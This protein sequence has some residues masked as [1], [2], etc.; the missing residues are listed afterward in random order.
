MRNWKNWL[1]PI[2][3]G[4]MVVALAL[5]PWRLSILRDESLT[6]TV[7]AEELAEDSNFPARPPELLGR[8]W[9]LVQRET[10]YADRMTIIGQALADSALEE[11]AVQ[12][13]AELAA[14]MEAGALPEET[15]GAASE[16]FAEKLC[17]RDQADLSSASFI[18]LGGYGKGREYHSLVLDGETGQLLSLEMESYSVMKSD[19]DLVKLGGA[20]LDRL[21]VEYELVSTDSS[22]SACFRLSDPR[23]LYWVIWSRTHLS[24]CPEI[25]WEALDGSDPLS[26]ARMEAM[27]ISVAI[28]GYDG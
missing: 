9:L 10:V 22:F 12:A 5:L 2:L 13:E 27:G 7:H 4:L 18:S 20:F 21:G 19:L 3:T 16:F 24:I 15:A 23:I 17:L 6:G 26:R 11:A 25:D 14:L 8:I 1:A 28:S